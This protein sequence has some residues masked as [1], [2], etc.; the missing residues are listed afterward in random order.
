MW[1]ILLHNKLKI[2][3]PKMATLKIDNF[4]ISACKDTRQVKILVNNIS[5]KSKDHMNIMG[6]TFDS[7]L[8]WAKHV[9]NQTNKAS[10]LYMKLN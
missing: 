9:A 5:V 3:P 6:L 7:K 1:N 10:M 4:N 8:T 2:N